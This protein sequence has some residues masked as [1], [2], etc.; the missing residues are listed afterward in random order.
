VATLIQGIW[1][2]SRYIWKIQNVGHRATVEEAKAKKHEG[3][4]RLLEEEY[5]LFESNNLIVNAAFCSLF[6]KRTM[7]ERK[8]MSNNSI[9]AWLPSVHSAKQFQKVFQAL[10]KR[11][12]SK[13]FTI[14]KKK[15]FTNPASKVRVLTMGAHST[16]D[17]DNGCTN[18]PSDASSTS[19]HFKEIDPG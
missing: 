7:T 8:G 19:I 6:T 11:S 12:S 5:A 10:L 1:E 13:Y 3:L 17:I 16:G 15:T 14:K 18:T 9:K 4:C 2:Y